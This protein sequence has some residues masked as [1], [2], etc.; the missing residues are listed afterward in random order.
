[1]MSR[2]R[3][4]TC[5]DFGLELSAGNQVGRPPK[6]VINW[7]TLTPA[8]HDRKPLIV[9]TPGRDAAVRQRC[10]ASHAQKSARQ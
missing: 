6:S 2:V 1:M 9:S 8:A 5:L 3:L 10:Y 4:A 7:F